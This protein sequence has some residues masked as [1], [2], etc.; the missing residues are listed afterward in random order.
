M[1][2]APALDGI[3]QG[4]LLAVNLTVYAHRDCFKINATV[5]RGIWS[6][7]DLYLVGAERRREGR[8]R[9]PLSTESQICGEAH[10][11]IHHEAIRYIAMVILL[12]G[13]LLGALIPLLLARR[14]RT[15]VLTWIFFVFSFTGTGVII[16]TAWLHLLSSA[17]QALRNE[18]LAPRLGEYDWPMFI[19]LMTVVFLVF[20]ETIA[21]S[22][23]SGSL[24]CSSGRNV[25][26]KSISSSDMESVNEQ[27]DVVIFQMDPSHGRF[28]PT[29]DLDT[30]RSQGSSHDTN[31][32][33]R[34]QL[35][36]LLVLEFEFTFH[37]VFISLILS[38]TNNLIT[39]TV[40]FACHQF[41]QGL[42]LGSRLAIAQW[43]PHG[44]WW[45]YLLA[46]IFG[47]SSPLA[48]AVG[49][50]AKPESPEIQLIMT[51]V[52]GAISG[53]ILLYTGMVELLGREFL[54]HSGMSR[55][56]LSVK[57][58]AFVCVGLGVAAMAVLAIWA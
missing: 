52:F 24:P 50:M 26:S 53:G 35:T 31:L 15:I 18:C 7:V 46:V 9:S 33:M 20:I 4:R 19:G 2:L 32:N 1:H 39:L 34:G 42:D 17:I 58:F 40:I 29:S 43:P 21:S 51:G 55:E 23:D 54:L 5:Q 49:L 48:V 16:S 47:I 56:P 27:Q 3:R 30:S 36:A 38:T 44:R 25:L 41:F 37:S 14:P 28:H 13:S 6:H 10:V 12:V 57:L 8:E 22:F 45:P 11:D